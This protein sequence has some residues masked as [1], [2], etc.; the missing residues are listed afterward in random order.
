MRKFM[1]AMKSNMV[2]WNPME[3]FNFILACEDYNVYQFDMRNLE[4]ALMIHKDH[5]SAVLAVAFS[6]TGREFVSG[7]YDRTIRLF[8][9]TTGH[10]RE[11][12]HAKR[13]QRVF[14]VSFSSDSRF[15]LSGSEDTNI[16]IW[17][18]NAAKELGVPSGRKQRKLLLNDALKK[19]YAHMPEV[20]RITK[21][22]NIPKPLKKAAK[23]RHIQREAE[24]RKDDNR[25]KHSRPEDNVVEP[26]RKRAVIKELV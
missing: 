17:K 22:K 20:S 8:N 18:T 23:L 16:R 26:E 24:K 10:S 1:L 19:R 7:S 25:K 5:V 13:M 9:T 4:R 12:Y 15:V 6:P 21:D 11:I 3:P 2:V 14:S